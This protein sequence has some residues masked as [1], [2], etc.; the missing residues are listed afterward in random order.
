MAAFY[1]LGYYVVPKFWKRDGGVQFLIL[2]AV[3]WQLSYLQ[4][5][6]GIRVCDCDI[7][8]RPLLI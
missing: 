1:V 2:F 7:P 4:D 8:P 5:E 3:Y 6:V